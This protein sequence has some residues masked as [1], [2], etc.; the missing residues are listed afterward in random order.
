VLGEERLREEL[1][2]LRLEMSHGAFF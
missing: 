1:C 2:G